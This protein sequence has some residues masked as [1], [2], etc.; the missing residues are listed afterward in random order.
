MAMGGD[1]I[2]R[3]SPSI[4]NR[5]HVLVLIRFEMQIRCPHIKGIQQHFVQELDDGSVFYAGSGV[6]ALCGFF[7]NVSSNSKSPPPLISVSM[8]SLV[9]LVL[10]STRR[11]S[12]SYSAIIQSTPIWV[13]NLIFSAAS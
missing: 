4:R 13:V 2:S 10:L 11:L 12:L 5:T 7:N 3:S 9:D 1:A 8:D 6:C